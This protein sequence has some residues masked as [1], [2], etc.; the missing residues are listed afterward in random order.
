MTP[1]EHTRRR[2]STQS[3][4]SDVDASLFFPLPKVKK[5]EPESD[6]LAIECYAYVDQ[7]RLLVD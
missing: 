2:V 5:W 7:A 4:R 3:T 6:L 1:V